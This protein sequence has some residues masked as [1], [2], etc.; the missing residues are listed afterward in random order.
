MRESE[1]METLRATGLP[2]DAVEVLEDTERDLPL[3]AEIFVDVCL[4]R[5]GIACCVCRDHVD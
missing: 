5:A 2:P 4:R 3:V 1:G